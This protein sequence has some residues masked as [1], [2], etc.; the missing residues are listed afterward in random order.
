M[1]ILNYKILMRRTLANLDFVKKNDRNEPEHPQRYKTPQDISPYGVTQRV[2]SYLG[3]FAHVYDE[4]LEREYKQVSG[5]HSFSPAR[6]LPIGWP[7]FQESK[8]I[9]PGKQT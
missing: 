4:T 8:T 7:D 5:G 6:A 2:N 1:H 9:A 3:A